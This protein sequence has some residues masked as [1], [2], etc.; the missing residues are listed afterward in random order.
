MACAS[1]LFVLAVSSRV[2]LRRLVQSL[3]R[4]HGERAFTH[5]LLS[6]SCLI[7]ELVDQESP[8]VAMDGDDERFLMYAPQFGLGNQQITLRNAVVW[9]LLLNRTLVLPHIVTHAGCSNDT[10][11]E[12]SARE[13][14]SHGDA[15]ELGD[16]APLRTMDMREYLRRGESPP[17]RLLVLAI[18]ALWAYRMTDDYWRLIGWPSLSTQPPL[19]VPLRGFRPDAITSAFGA[20][21]HHRALAFR[22][23]FAALEVS[24]DQ[25]PPPGIGWLNKVAMPGLYRPRASLLARA[26]EAERF[27][28]SGGAGGAGGSVAAARSRGAAPL[29]CVHIRIGDIV[30]D[31]ARYEAESKSGSGR[32]WVRAHFANGYSCFQPLP[33]IVANLRALQ[34]RAAKRQLDGSAASAAAAAAAASS[35]AAAPPAAIY[36]SIEDP[37]YAR[38]ELLAPFNLTVLADLE[39]QLRRAVQAAEPALP[40]GLRDTLLDQLV[41]ARSSHLVLNVFSTFSQMMLTRIG[42]DHPDEAGGW[43]RSLDAEQQRALGIDVDYWRALPLAREPPEAQPP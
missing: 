32:D 21:T 11:C 27:L 4:S 43:T 9:A 8:P 22:S 36:V 19:D 37:S 35:S 7:D 17:P 6:P 14:A 12:A 42:L 3:A 29:A 2:L 30:A 41:C 18:R 16:V 33:Q 1:A 40:R 39:P 24:P 26:D 5:R 31:C 10:L 23:L 20:C 28:R 13:L 38:H 25:Y 34:R 15:F